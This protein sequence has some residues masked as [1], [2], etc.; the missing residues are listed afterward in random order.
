MILDED[1]LEGEIRG[2]G[3]AK[4]EDWTIGEARGVLLLIFLDDPMSN[5][6]KSRSHGGLEVL[7]QEGFE[8]EV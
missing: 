6:L 1:S 7:Y 8:I 5:L 4:P 3:F 2:L